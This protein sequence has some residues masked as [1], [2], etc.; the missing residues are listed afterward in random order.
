MAEENATSA[1]S[2]SDQSQTQDQGQSSD[3]TADQTQTQQTSASQADQSADDQ[4]SQASEP[5]KTVLGDDWYDVLAGGDEKT[6]KMLRRYSSAQNAI[7]GHMSLRAKMDSGELKS[8]MPDP[9]DEKAVQAWR[10]A[11]SI[12]AEA[13]GYLEDVEI[14]DTIK[15]VATPYLDLAHEMGMPKAD[16]EKW[17][18]RMAEQQQAQLEAITER[19]ITFKREAEDDLRARY[20]AEYRANMNHFANVMVPLMGDELFEDFNEARFPDG[21]RFADDPRVMDF[22]VNIS[23]Q[24][25]PVGTVP[26]PNS[27]A[28]MAA[29]NSRI[30]EIEA[31]IRAGGE[32][33]YSSQSMQDEYQRLLMQKERMRK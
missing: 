10:E 9:A 16:V 28:A 5:V 8:A 31:D 14:D 11:N 26:M 2:A 19:D 24:L 15:A 33:Y 22:M 3:Q 29:M 27:E 25:E 30:E 13:T 12:P 1:D 6:A 21:R 20:G 4:Q 23:R 32:K 18:G 7:K 17:L